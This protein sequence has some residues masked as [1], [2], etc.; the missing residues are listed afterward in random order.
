[1]EF[2]IAAQSKK[3]FVKLTNEPVVNLGALITVWEIEVAMTGDDW[4]TGYDSFC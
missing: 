4:M 1:L 3:R 2:V